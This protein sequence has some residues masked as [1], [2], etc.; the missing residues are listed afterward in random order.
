MVT[1]SF[2]FFV[3]C[4]S[5]FSYC[6][7]PVLR[8]LESWLWESLSIF[9]EAFCF[10]FFL[11]HSR[12]AHC[13]LIFLRPFFSRVLSISR[14]LFMILVLNLVDTFDKKEEREMGFV[15]FLHAHFILIRRQCSHLCPY[16]FV[17]RSFFSKSH[18][19][20]TKDAHIIFFFPP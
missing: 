10:F 20:F 17:E 19:R 8:I 14:E 9:F 12:R 1:C 18:R 3:T 7:P 16:F 6:S 15:Q 11:Y 13:A 5:L 2:T 4:C